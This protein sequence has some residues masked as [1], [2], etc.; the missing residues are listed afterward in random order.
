MAIRSR[1]RT[2]LA[3]TLIALFGAVATYLG[4][5]AWARQTDR[6]VRVAVSGCSTD[7][8]PWSPIT[9]HYL[10]CPYEIDA[11]TASNWAQTVF[12]PAQVAEML[13]WS[14][15]TGPPY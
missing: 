9:S 10:R 5:Y 11:G 2:A 3:V 8:C 13:V 15:W 7:Q 14:D 4:G 6:L 1:D 12:A